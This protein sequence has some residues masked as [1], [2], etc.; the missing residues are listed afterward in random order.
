MSTALENL[1][2]GR[3]RLRGHFVGAVRLEGGESIGD[4]AYLL[5]VRTDSGTPKETTLTDADIARGRGLANALRTPRR[6]VSMRI[7]ASPAIPSPSPY[8]A[9]GEIAEAQ[10]RV[11]NL[12]GIVVHPGAQWAI[13]KDSEGSPFGSRRNRSTARSKSAGIAARHLLRERPTARRRPSAWL[14]VDWLTA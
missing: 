5:R 4:G 12:G 14:V 9:V 1:T 11:A 13:C 3:V 6:S 7:D 2:R 8:F 10:D